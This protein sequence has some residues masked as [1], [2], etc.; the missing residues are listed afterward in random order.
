MKLFKLLKYIFLLFILS[1]SSLIIFL[2]NI[3]E[4]LP[5]S[6]ISEYFPNEITKIYDE[7]YDLL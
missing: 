7:K 2:W 4:E 3:Q 6:N 1:I 5:D